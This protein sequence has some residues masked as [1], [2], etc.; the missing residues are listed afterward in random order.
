LRA[1]VRRA[2]GRSQSASGLVAAP[3]GGHASPAISHLTSL[4]R[5]VSP[6]PTSPLPPSRRLSPPPSLDNPRP[7]RPTA[8]R[9]QSSVHVHLPSQPSVPLPCAREPLRPHSFPL[10]STDH[11]H[12]FR[13]LRPSSIVHRPPPIFGPSPSRRSPRSFRRSILLRLP[14]AT[15]SYN[16]PR[17]RSPDRSTK[18]EPSLRR[19]KLRRPLSTCRTTRASSFVQRPRVRTGAFVPQ[20]TAR[21]ATS[22]HCCELTTC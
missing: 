19:P 6:S 7:E 15:V 18:P 1:L 13:A 16:A 9:T 22:V 21:I 2:L 17:Q 3:R 12:S 4:L 11:R 20:A 8:L 10:I 5:V 14:V